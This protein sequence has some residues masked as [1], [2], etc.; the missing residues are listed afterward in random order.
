MQGTGLFIYTTKLLVLN[1]CEIWSK[2]YRAS[3]LVQG[4]SRAAQGLMIPGIECE[5]LYT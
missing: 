3:G 5:I 1:N 4:H 2:G